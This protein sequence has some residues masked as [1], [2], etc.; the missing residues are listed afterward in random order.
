MMEIAGVST[1]SLDIF[2][3]D[4]RGDTY[5]LLNDRKTNMVLCY[6]NSNVSCG[7][8]Y[9]TGNSPNKNPEIIYLLKGEVEFRWFNV[10]DLTNSNI[11]KKLIKAPS[12]IVVPINIWHELYTLSECIF[13]ELNSMSDGKS[14]CIKLDIA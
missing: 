7:K 14:D 8:H 4:N 5:E 2:F 12:K 13:L 3:S 11:S 10:N 1:E 9:H 6:R